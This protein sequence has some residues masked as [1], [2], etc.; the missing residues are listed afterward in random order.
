[1]TSTDSQQVGCPSIC[2]STLS[3]PR[4]ESRAFPRP[5]GVQLSFEP[6]G[7]RPAVAAGLAGFDPTPQYG[8]LPGCPGGAQEPDTHLFV[9]EAV[10]DADEHGPADGS[11]LGTGAL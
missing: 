8:S 10:P 1:M 2:T 6:A 5:R 3:F 9:H 7:P 11:L 4:G